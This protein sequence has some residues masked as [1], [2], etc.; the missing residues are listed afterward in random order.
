V[1]PRRRAHTEPGE[2]ED[3]AAWAES[4][5]ASDEGLVR[6]FERAV[7]DHVGVPQAVAV[8]S[9][10]RG[11]TLIFEHLGLKQGD[12]VVV[13]AYTLAD[14]IPI[15]QGFGAAAVPADVD[16]DTLNV[17]VE[18]VE[19]RL[20]P[21]TEA[22]L[23]LH[24]FGSPCDI[25]AIAALGWQHNVPVIEDCAH[26]LGAGLAGRQTGSFGWAGFFSFDTMKSL[27]TFGGGMVVSRDEG[28]VDHIRR[29]TADGGLDLASARQKMG[30]FRREERIFASRFACP[31][32]YL[33]AT[34]SL[35]Q[36]M[37]RLYRA[38]GQHAPPSQIRYSPVQAKLGLSKLPGLADR[39]AGRRR[40]AGLLCSLLRPEIRP[41]QV[42]DGADPT[43]YF[44]VA[45]LP[46]P[47]APIRKKLL[48]KGIDAGVGAE[49]A[50]NTARLLGYD[51]CPHVGD[52][53]SRAIALPMFDGIPE[54]ALHR[55]A[56]ALNGLVAG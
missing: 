53:E 36:P 35:R 9:G 11:M 27:N 47:A 14:L 51:D 48:L 50:Q 55:V 16:P 22:I 3:V 34:P 40:S 29:R 52:V 28:L 39:M 37:G 5:V 46:C 20:S 56:D 26:S 19:R 24:A 4:G 54:K 18:A 45:T 12:E 8:N 44:F 33:L 10:R 15:I 30:A 23:A 17:S 21:S 49:V 32:L 41:Q 42:I 7:A 38:L 25:E 2:L 1:I 13:P 6:E 31:L 43:W